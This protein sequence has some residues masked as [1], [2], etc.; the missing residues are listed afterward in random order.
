MNS[1]EQLLANPRVTVRREGM[2]ETNR[3]LSDVRYLVGSI[4]VPRGKPL[5]RWNEKDGNKES[6]LKEWIKQGSPNLESLLTPPA[7]CFSSDSRSRKS[8]F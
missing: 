2:P 4:A 6:A 8:R 1:I 7:V 5:F 3:F